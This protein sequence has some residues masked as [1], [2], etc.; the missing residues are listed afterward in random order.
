LEHEKFE[1]IGDD[2]KTSINITLK[3]ALL[4]F[5]VNIIHLDGHEVKIKRK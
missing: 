5:E 4:G 2:L 1:R 3:Q